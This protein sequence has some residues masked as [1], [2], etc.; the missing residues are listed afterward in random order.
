MLLYL[1]QHAEAKSE[2][3][4]PS[5]GLTMKGLA[6]VK[7]VAD[8]ISGLDIKV[9]KICHSGKTRSMQTAHVLADFIQSEDGV[10]PAK[11]LAPMDDPGAWSTLLDDEK[12]NVMLVGHLP[13][14][15]RLS[16]LLLCGDR[17]KKLI[18]FTMGCVVCLKKSDDGIWSVEW[19][20][21][22]EV[23]R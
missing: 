18:D 6:D 21:T 23:I 2:Q 15:G 3:E 19:M 8:F 10:E 13:H 14:L 9:K 17:E 11:G 12:N 16:S 7:K 22:P 20:I 5:R 4:D 1:V